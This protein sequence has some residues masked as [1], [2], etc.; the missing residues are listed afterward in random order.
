MKTH[1]SELEMI[2]D[3]LQKNPKG[4]K[5]T[6]I[7]RELAMNRNAAAKFLEILLMTG[8]V[9][10]LE[11]DMSKIFILSKRT[12]I[13]TML[14][15]SADFI[16]VL[17]KDMKIARINDNFLEFAG[18]NRQDILGKNLTMAGLPIMMEPAVNQKLQEARSGTDIKTEIKFVYRN[19]EFFFDLRMTP[20][21]FNDGKPG[22]TVILEDVTGQRKRGV[23]L[24]ESEAHLRTLFGESP[25]GT[26]V[27][28][29][30]GALVNANPSFRKTFGAKNLDAAGSLNLFSLPGMPPESLEALRRNRQVKFES[31]IDTV[32][33]N[34]Q[35]NGQAGTKSLLEFHVTPMKNGQQPAG[36]I[37]QVNE[38][39]SR[40]RF[41]M[42]NAT[43]IIARFS[44]ELKY[45]S[46]KWG[47]REITGESPES[48]IGKSNT[49]LGIHPE[50]AR[51]WNNALTEVFRTKKSTSREFPF[52][53]GDEVCWYRT[54]FTP[55]HGEC[56]EVVS[57]I[58]L[59]RD[60]TAQKVAVPHDEQTRLLEGI[61][62]CIDEPV[63]LVDYRRGGIA[64]A[65]D[66]A[67]KVFG[68]GNGRDLIARD[69]WMVLGTGGAILRDPVQLNEMFGSNSSFETVSS[70]QRSDGREFSG[71]LLFRTVPGDTGGLRNIIVLIRNIG[72]ATLA[73]GQATTRMWSP[74]ASSGPAPGGF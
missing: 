8:Q 52:P 3:L 5:I 43:D 63:I 74:S 39:D 45:L 60:I 16:L 61:L 22:I 59:T 30:S 27:F 31:V 70:M 32:P 13:P 57:V 21:V 54:E 65:N 51:C 14:D 46:V 68:C 23:L 50:T 48:C 25:V 26:A 4:M 40:L 10:M 7:A 58:A 71:T 2:K 19:E 64:F 11:Y 41:V 28:D 37:L 56:G 62:S 42:D 72:S 33:E 47:I 1:E 44:H 35:E 36:Y 9:E 12:G 6:R 55:E 53:R 38:S 69:P 18:L 15:H 67:G 29:A 17:D 34:G 24:R 73:R 20:T 66:A 49:D